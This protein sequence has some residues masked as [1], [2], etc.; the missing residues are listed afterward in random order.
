MSSKAIYE[1]TGKEILKRNLGDT[2]VASLIR[3]A[4]ITPSSDFENV[5]QENPW[6]S[7]MV[8]YFAD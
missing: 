2:K 6:L 4:E 7:N 5:L 3:F 8:W 1:A